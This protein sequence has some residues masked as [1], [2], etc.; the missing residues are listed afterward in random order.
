MAEIEKKICDKKKLQELLTTKPTLQNVLE[1]IPHRDKKYE[2]IHE[3]M[4]EG[5]S[6]TLKQILSN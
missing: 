4:G 1:G 5:K 3:N 2:H 6:N